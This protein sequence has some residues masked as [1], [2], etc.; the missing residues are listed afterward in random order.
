MER[1][2]MAPKVY[3]DERTILQDVVGILE[4][5]TSDWDLEFSGGIGPN[6]HLIADLAFE[7]IDMVQFIV[8][9]EEQFMRRDLPVETLLMADG[10]YVDD[11]QVAQVVDF[12]SKHLNR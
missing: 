12:L 1:E 9:L 10:R 2:E 11:L 8:A 7:S 4:D 3:L 6:T 5:M